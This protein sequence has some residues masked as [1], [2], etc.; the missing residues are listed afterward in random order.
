M[1]DLY[2]EHLAQAFRKL[3]EC[4]AEHVQTVPVI[5]RFKDKTVP[6]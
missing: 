1:S 5:E 6:E 3:H 4:E 2:I